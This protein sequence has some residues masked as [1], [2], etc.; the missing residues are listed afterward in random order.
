VDKRKLGGVKV[1]F[2]PSFTAIEGTQNSPSKRV[3]DAIASQLNSQS[4]P[5]LF[6]DRDRCEVHADLLRRIK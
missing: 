5:I 6:R 3:E 2:H 4:N 1:L